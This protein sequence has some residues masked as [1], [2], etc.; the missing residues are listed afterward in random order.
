MLALIVMLVAIIIV[1]VMDIAAITVA[2]KVDDE[3][4][5]ERPELIK[6]D[7]EE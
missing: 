3:M 2:S 4:R 6:L 5:I 7:E 1:A